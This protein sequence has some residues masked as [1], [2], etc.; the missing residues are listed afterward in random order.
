VPADRQPRLC[1]IAALCVH[2]FA[3]GVLP[4]GLWRIPARH[5]LGR[6][7][8]S[9]EWLAELRFSDD[10]RGANVWLAVPKDQ[11]VFLGAREAAGLPRV[12][13]VQVC[14][15]LKDHPERSAE[16]D[17]EV[18]REFMPWSVR[19]GQGAARV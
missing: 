7:A 18:R 11:G 15:D 2:S 8:S 9:P 10:P 4:V 6:A 3:G 19:R 17:A 12:S 1:G 16:A 14:L 13:P 5:A